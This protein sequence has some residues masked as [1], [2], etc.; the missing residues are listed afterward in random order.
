MVVEKA[1]FVGLDHVSGRPPLTLE[2]GSVEVGG[3]E[4]RRAV[5]P[6]LQLALDDPRPD[7]GQRAAHRPLP[8][9]YA[10]LG[11]HAGDRAGFGLAVA[12]GDL[13]SGGLAEGADHLGVE[14]LAGRDHPVDR[15]QGLQLRPACQDA[16][17]GRGLAEDV[18]LL[19]AD[20][21][22][23]RRRVEALIHEQGRSP[24]EPRCDEGVSRRLRPSRC[25]RAPGQVAG[26]RSEPV[27]GLELL[28]GQVALRMDHP[29]RL[30]GRPGSEDD[31]GRVVRIE[32]GAAGRCGLVEVLVE[33]PGEVVHV[34]VID[35]SGQ[36]AQVLRFTDR[37]CRIRRGH[38]CCQVARGQ[39]RVAG[40]GHG[41]HP[42]AGQHRDHP[43]DPVSDQDQDR[44][45]PPHSF[46]QHH[47]GKAEAACEEVAEVVD[48]P[49]PFGV[50]PDHRLLREREALDYVFDE[51]Q[52]SPI[53]SAGGVRRQTASTREFRRAWATPSGTE[54]RPSGRPDSRTAVGIR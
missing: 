35:P 4:G 30:A 18:D 36:V 33:G 50:D 6:D 51:V 29:R 9:G 28:A 7:P 53:I 12:V 10:V 26:P 23:S 16:E 44:V 21:V 19:P 5:R 15:R 39:L 41:A 17:F 31:Q 43:F 37:Q 14:A 20:D 25:R 22:E 52:G 47:P 13:Q 46:C 42:E 27:F 40:K 2:P 1:V 3:E 45:A 38:P 48:G 24:A 49:A 32:P 11:T 34:E 8:S 54:E